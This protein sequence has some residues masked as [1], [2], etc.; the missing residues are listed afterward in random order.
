MRLR[1]QTAFKTY[2]IPGSL[3]FQRPL[4]GCD[5]SI[6]LNRRLAEKILENALSHHRRKAERAIRSFL[7]K[8][9]RHLEVHRLKRK[10]LVSHAAR[11][12]SGKTA[13]VTSIFTGTRHYA[14]DGMST[15]VNVAQHTSP[16]LIPGSRSFNPLRVTAIDGSSTTSA[17]SSSEFQAVLSD[18]DVSNEEKNRVSWIIKQGERTISRFDRHG[19]SLTYDIPDELD[20]SSFLVMAYVQ[21]PSTDVSL[22]VHVGGDTTDISAGGVEFI[23][24]HEGFRSELYNDPAGHCTIGFGHLVHLGECTE[25]DQ[26][27]YPEGVTREEALE[28]LRDDSQTAC[29]AIN[30][31]VDVHLNQNQFDAL[32]SFIYN[33]GRGNF[34]S[35]TLLTRLNV[36]AYDEVPDQLNLW[37]RSGGTE[38]PGLVRRRQEEGEMFSQ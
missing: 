4:G 22:W 26:E 2:D 25:E 5:Q 36:G 27:Q 7:S 19:P 8:E 37:T 9:E 21:S 20:S 18:G 14:V 33:V 16:A 17:D 3:S 13:Y 6:R 34:A 32:A 30:D 38:L 11:A 35:S 31:L 28:L 24:G 1:L 29:D 12:L 10:K 15:H 23:S